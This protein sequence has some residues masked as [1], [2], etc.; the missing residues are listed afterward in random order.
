MNWHRNA[1]F[2]APQAAFHTMSVEEFSQQ[3]KPHSFSLAV[4]NMTLMASLDLP[5]LLRAVARLLH[6]GAHFVFTVTHPCFWPQYWNYSTADWFH[7][8]QEITVEAPFKISLDAADTV[9]THIHRPLSQYV[10]NL[11]EAGFLMEAVV[12]PCPPPD[13]DS[14]YLQKWKQPRF[15]AV[16]CIRT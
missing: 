1:F 7:Y 12:E 15:L 11:T 5:S 16:R 14:A 2:K 10:N 4:A 9:T 13:T 6:P 8:N 3:A